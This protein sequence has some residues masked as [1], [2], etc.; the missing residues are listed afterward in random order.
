M[1]LLNFMEKY[2]RVIY[3]TSEL[4]EWIDLAKEMKRDRGWQPIYWVTTA[5]NEDSIK[6]AFPSVYAQNYVD[7]LRGKYIDIGIDTQTFLDKNIVL[8][9]QKYERIAI[10]MMDRMDA[11]AYSFNYSERLQLYYDFLAYWIN[12]IEALDIDY[13]LFSESPHSLF[14]Y[15]LY[16]VAMENG[17]KILRFTPTHIDGLTFLSYDIEKAPNYL[18]EML[19]SSLNPTPKAQRYLDKNRGLYGDALPYYMKDLT[20]RNSF[21]ENLKKYGGKAQRFLSYTPITAYKKSTSHALSVSN[22]T[23]AN[24]LF[25]KLKGFSVKAKLKKRYA[26]LSCNADLTK[27]YVY[28]ALHYQPEKTTS[29]EGDIFVEQWLMVQMLS[30]LAPK[31]WKI[32]VKEHGSQFNEKLYGEQGRTHDFYDRLNAFD[33]V[34]LISSEISSFDLIDSA[35]AVATVTGTVGIESVIRSTPLLSF[36]YAWYA[37]C[38]GVFVIKN[39]DE[40]EDAFKK[41]AEGQTINSNKVDSFLYAIE[42]ISSSCYLN[43]GNKVGVS[44]GSEE[45]LKNLLTCLKNYADKV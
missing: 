16:V 32:Y 6:E 15:L 20:K 4:D 19:N 43:P 13:I 40:L 28:V 42:H 31:G 26:K 21:M 33:N 10:K 35:K 3:A 41:I 36:G 39:R 1:S 22:I 17:V 29:P 44:F 45:N 11:T 23:K 12:V 5:K 38:E 14:T 7:A 24:L 2:M 37:L 18:E 8:S 30:R 27:P 34:T 25:Y 9:Y